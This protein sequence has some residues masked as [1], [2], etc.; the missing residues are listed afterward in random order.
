MAS[1]P[2]SG[3][4]AASA[5]QLG[6]DLRAVAGAGE[7]P[8]LLDERVGVGAQVHGL[9]VGQVAHVGVLAAVERDQVLELAEHAEGAAA[10]AWPARTDARAVLEV[11]LATAGLLATG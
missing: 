5:L 10:P 8:D 6:A 11:L 3:W 4:A 7:H 9:A 1:Q 2:W